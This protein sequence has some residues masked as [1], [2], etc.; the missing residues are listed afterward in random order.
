MKSVLPSNWPPQP[1]EWSRLSE[2][3]RSQRAAELYALNQGLAEA[4]RARRAARRAPRQ[5]P[6]RLGKATRRRAARLLLA[7]SRRVDAP[8][9]PETPDAAAAP[10]APELCLQGVNP[11]A[12]SVDT[13]GRHR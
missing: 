5:R 12:H 13:T 8:Y 4:A 1:S 3:E 2:R 11:T 10:R 9:P 6:A 7:I